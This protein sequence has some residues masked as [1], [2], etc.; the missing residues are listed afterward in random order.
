LLDL[1]LTGSNDFERISDD[2]VDGV[3]EGFY[4]YVDEAR[5]DYLFTF[6]HQKI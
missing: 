6:L 2:I 5:F 1:V 4:L 3:I